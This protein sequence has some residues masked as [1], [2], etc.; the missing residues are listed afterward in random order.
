MIVERRSQAE[1]RALSEQRLLEAAV[2]LI[3][4]KG[5][6]RTTLAEIGE[7]AGYS[8]GLVNQRFGSKRDLVR[9][10]TRRIQQEFLE[11]TLLPALDGETGLAALLAVVDTCVGGLDRA[12]ETARAFYVLLGESIG[13]VPEIRET[14]ALANREFRAVVEREI[15]RGIEAGEIRPDVEASA[16]TGL[17]VGS[18]RGIAIQW[19]VDPDSLDLD[20]LRRELRQSLERTL[21]ADRD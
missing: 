21:R 7:R 20:S 14:L 8:R 12:G 19:L 5:S 15:K 9:H 16:Q 13:P 6:S 18:L 11:Q 10:L 2:R 17:L 3:A 4:E 1:R